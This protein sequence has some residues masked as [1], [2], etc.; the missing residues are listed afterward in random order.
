MSRDGGDRAPEQV[1]AEWPLPRGQPQV[2]GP[3]GLGPPAPRAWVQV[4]PGPES[5]LGGPC[6]STKH[7][8]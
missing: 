5:L 2:W 3:A 4:R 7:V 6:L 8:C 1:E